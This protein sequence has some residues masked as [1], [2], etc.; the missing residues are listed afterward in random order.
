MPEGTLTINTFLALIRGT[1]TLQKEV[2]KRTLMKTVAAQTQESAELAAV[3]PAFPRSCRGRTMP[4]PSARFL[5]CRAAPG[6]PQPGFVSQAPHTGAQLCSTPAGHPPGHPHASLQPLVSLCQME[7]LES[8][9]QVWQQQSRGS[10][11]CPPKNPWGICCAVTRP[12]LVLPMSAAANAEK[13]TSNV[14]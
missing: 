1:K 12:C 13:G 7:M 9:S 10:L 3:C 8:P 14:L 2:G 11:L 5:P 6:Q 4:C